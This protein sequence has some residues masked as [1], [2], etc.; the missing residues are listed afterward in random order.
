MV[1]ELR[2]LLGMLCVAFTAATAEAEPYTL[3]YRAA[4]GAEAGSGD[5]SPYYVASRHDGIT[6]VSPYAFYTTDALWRPMNDSTR[7]SYGYGLQVTAGYLSPIDYQRYD[8]ATESWTKHSVSSTGW[9][10]QLYGELRWRSLFLQAG[11]KNYDRSIMS[12]SLGSGDITYSDNARPVPQIRLGLSDFRDFPGTKGWL[13]VQG[14]IAF[15]KFIDNVWLRNQYN[16]YNHFVTTGVWM[17]YKRLYFRIGE[18]QPFS[19]T[20][21]MQHAAQF[22]GTQQDFKNGKLVEQRKFHKNFWK[23]I[24]PTR[25]EGSAYYDGNHL[26]SWDVKMRYRFRNGST[27]TAYIQ[28]P[29]EDGS[30]IGKLN[31]WDGLYGLEYKAARSGIVDNVVAEYIDFTNQSGP[32]HWAPGDFPGTSVP[33]EATGSDDYYNNYAYNGW[34]NFGMSM[35]S[36]FVMS[37]AYNLDGYGAFT[38]NRLRG[39]HIGIGGTPAAAWTY[40]IMFSHRTSWGTPYIPSA[41]RR[42]SVSALAQCAWSPR[43]LPALKVTGALGIDHGSLYGNN[44]GVAVGVEYSGTIRFGKKH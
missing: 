16:R 4:I 38:A 39:F 44:F 40:R 30:G 22:G 10:Q 2:Y 27:L 34:A 8:A 33:G 21:G 25:G 32:M 42:H 20:I 29:W 15:G 18:R 13:Q 26:G 19:F 3:Q 17:H 36:P 5:F 11:M 28:S 31:G 9:L 37:P 35:G 41:H 14:E 24:M 12:P 6:G 7:F 43:H 1:K 23:I